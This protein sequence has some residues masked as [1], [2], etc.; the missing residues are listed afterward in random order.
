[1]ELCILEILSQP[2]I[3]FACSVSESVTAQSRNIID[4]RE[5]LI[6]FS[7]GETDMAVLADGVSQVR[8]KGTARLYFPDKKYVISPILT[9]ESGEIH[10]VSAAVRID[11]M[12]FERVQVGSPAEAV[13]LA[14]SLGPEKIILAEE[15]SLT[16]ERREMMMMHMQS[17]LTSRLDLSA[18]GRMK[19]L[20]LW[21]EIIALLD[22]ALRAQLYAETERDRRAPSS[23]YYHIYRIKKYVAEHLAE[24]LTVN[25]IADAVGLSADYVGRIFRREC[26]ET[27]NG[28]IAHS[29]VNLLGNLIR[30]DTATPLAR[31]A[32]QAGFSDIRYAQR[33]FKHCT[34]ITMTRYRQIN[35]GLTLLH[36]DPWKEAGLEKDIFVGAEEEKEN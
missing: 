16:R 12:K 26:K 31:L 10:M 21:Y 30:D 27:L 36:S 33:V 35:H 4:H 34:G 1:M 14:E 24:E 9:Q 28:Y 19:S 23:V 18:A 6:E 3:E 8:R 5:N 22:S 32:A 13:G 17:L 20:A 25:G 11:R 2:K 29:R 7:L 15:I